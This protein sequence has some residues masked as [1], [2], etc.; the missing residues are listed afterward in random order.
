[1][2]LIDFLK[3]L[4]LLNDFI[5]SAHL[6]IATEASSPALKRVDVILLFTLNKDGGNFE[7]KRVTVE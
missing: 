1:L 7:R 6:V 4:L 3:I 2:E 5:V